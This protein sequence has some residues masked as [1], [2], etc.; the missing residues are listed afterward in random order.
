MAITKVVRR[1]KPA[2]YEVN[3]SGKIS[4]GMST[5]KGVVGNGFQRPVTES[6]DALYEKPFEELKEETEAYFKARNE[7]ENGPQVANEITVFLEHHPEYWRYDDTPTGVANG[8]A[9]K[10]ELYSPEGQTA[11]QKAGRVAPNFSDL[12]MAFE[13]CKQKGTV[14]LHQGELQKQQLDEVRRRVSGGQV[15]MDP[16]TMPKHQ[17]RAL[18]NGGRIDYDPLGPKY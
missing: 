2:T 4:V 8:K 9:I 6:E 11:M 12:E 14:T 3:S 5:R 15:D 7:R 13:R 18:A 16:Y 17:L 1:T 10:A